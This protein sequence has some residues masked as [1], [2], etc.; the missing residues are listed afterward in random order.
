M[1]PAFNINTIHFE[2]WTHIHIVC[3]EFLLLCKI[4]L[5]KEFQ[6]RHQI[7]FH[8]I[9]MCVCCVWFAL[10]FAF[11][12]NKTKQN[13]KCSIFKSIQIDKNKNRSGNNSGKPRNCKN[14]RKFLFCTKRRQQTRKQNIKKRK[15]LWNRLETKRKKKYYDKYNANERSTHNRTR[16]MER[17][18]KRARTVSDTAPW[19]K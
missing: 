6:T 8:Y 5:C 4:I 2:Q 10:A 12:K 16:M 14:V 1:K 18:W 3:T 19:N 11:A 7:Q 9:F 13:K 15:K 17:E